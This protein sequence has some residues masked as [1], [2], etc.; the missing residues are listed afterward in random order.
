MTDVYRWNQARIRP[1]VGDETIKLHSMPLVRST[2][3]TWEH[4]QIDGT[5]K[6]EFKSEDYLKRFISQAN[7][8]LG[9]GTA[10]RVYLCSVQR[11]RGNLAIISPETEKSIE[12][13][14]DELVKA[15][16]TLLLSD[17]LHRANSILKKKDAGAVSFTRSEMQWLYENRVKESS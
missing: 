15:G 1:L 8:L 13:N 4:I 3:V 6:L 2:A 12:V 16:P 7:E 9:D 17:A 5:L 10:E 11:S 14:Y